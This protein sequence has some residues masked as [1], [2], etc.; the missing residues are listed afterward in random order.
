MAAGLLVVTGAAHGRVSKQKLLEKVVDRVE[1]VSVQAP[2]AGEVCF[3]PGSRCDLKLLKFVESAQKSLEIAIYDVNLDELVHA[4]LVQSKKIPVRVLVD[5]RQA[6]G[7]HSLVSTLVKGGVSVRMGRQ[8]GIMHHKFTLVDGSRLETGS[9]NYTNHA[10]M[11]NQENQIYL[12][13]PA[14]VSRYRVRFDEI[15]EQGRPYGKD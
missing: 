11:A 8:R 9:F 1:A 12:D 2:K 10:S 13:D 3:T 7:G 14:I 5:Q 4:I 6:K 15:W